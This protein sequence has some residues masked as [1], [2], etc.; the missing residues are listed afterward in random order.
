MFIHGHLSL[1]QLVLQRGNEAAFCILRPTRELFE[2]CKNLRGR[3]IAEL[4]ED[5]QVAYE[6]FVRQCSTGFAELWEVRDV[7]FRVE[8]FWSHGSSSIDDESGPAAR[9]PTPKKIF[10]LDLRLFKLFYLLEGWNNSSLSAN[11]GLIDE[12]PECRQVLRSHETEKIVSRYSFHQE[13]RVLV[14]VFEFWE[15]DRT[16][17]LG[18]TV[19]GQKVFLF[20]FSDEFVFEEQLEKH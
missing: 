12:I 14:Q 5:V 1:H 10:Q 13:H 19:P 11:H 16:F 2:E 18:N 7:E 17:L 6:I 4:C 9:D 20:D 3:E 15:F 8:E